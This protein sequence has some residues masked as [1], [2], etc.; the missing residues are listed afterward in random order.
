MR[1]L[2]HATDATLLHNDGLLPHM[3]HDWRPALR[4]KGVDLMHAAC[5]T[6]GIRSPAL[7]SE[8]IV[9]QRAGKRALGFALRR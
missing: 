8:L 9:S 5:F 6:Q 2:M 7:C 3:R 4:E 1:A